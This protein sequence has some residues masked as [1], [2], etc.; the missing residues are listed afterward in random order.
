MREIGSAPLEAVG[1]L[2][3]LE[4]RPPGPAWRDM[5]S[6]ARRRRAG[7]VLGMAAAVILAVG[8]LSRLPTGSGYPDGTSGDGTSQQS[9]DVVPDGVPTLPSATA[10]TGTLPPTP[11]TR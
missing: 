3:E 8:A 6:R 1:E 4:D 10:Y 5:D 7:R 11:R 9:E 2:W